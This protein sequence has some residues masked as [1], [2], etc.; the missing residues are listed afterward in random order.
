MGIEPDTKDWTW[1]LERPCLECG[2]DARAL[3]L[4]R[5]P[6]EIEQN[7]AQWTRV[8][9]A[10]DARRRPAPDR[11]SP[12]EYGAHVRDVNRIFADRVALMLAEDDPEFANWDQDETARAEDYASQD[13]ATVAA[14]VVEAAASV[15]ARYREVPDD[16]WQRTG[17][18]SNGS[19]FTVDSLARYHLHDVVHHAYDVGTGKRP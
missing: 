10:S 18:R 9:S 8:L 17:R 11:W 4:V 19:R 7:A 5:L 2:F 16:A 13:P 14:E 12:L 1:V 6:D 15:A 3:E